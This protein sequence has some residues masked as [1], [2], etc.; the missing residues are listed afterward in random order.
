MRRREGGQL[1]GTRSRPPQSGLRAGMLCRP[2]CYACV[3]WP[4]RLT[5]T[6]SEASYALGPIREA[7]G[8]MA[9]PT[10][11]PASLSQ[12]AIPRQTPEVRAV[13]GNAA[14]TDLCGGPPARAVP[15]ATKSPPPPPPWAGRAATASDPSPA[16]R[17]AAHAARHRLLRS[18]P[19][20]TWQPDQANPVHLLLSAPLAIAL[21][22]QSKPRAHGMPGSD[23]SHARCADRLAHTPDPSLSPRDTPPCC[24]TLRSRKPIC[25]ATTGILKGASIALWPQP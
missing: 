11:D 8:P 12:R 1:K 5:R 14:R 15:T 13:C 18:C 22:F 19:L 20:A 4:T 25:A 7:G 17:R 2:D 3:K 16:L 9:P 23:P 21:S 10:Q 6:E 24:A